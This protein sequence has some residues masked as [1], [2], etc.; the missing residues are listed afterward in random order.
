MPG[1]TANIE[2]KVVA[3]AILSQLW[4]VSVPEVSIRGGYIYNNTF[5]LDFD[6]NRVDVV[7]KR[8]NNLFHVHMG[9]GSADLYMNEISSNGR[10]WPK[11]KGRSLVHIN[12][13]T[14]E[15]DVKLTT[16]TNSEGSVV[17]GVEVKD[18][19]LEMDKD[20]IIV[21]MWGDSHS[22]FAN[23]MK[24]LYKDDMRSAITKAAQ[25]KLDTITNL[26]S[27]DDEPGVTEVSKGV[28]FDWRLF[29]APTIVNN[30]L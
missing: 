6:S 17:L 9:S 30:H 2:L 7:K 1:I 16:K 10:S 20:D 24:I 14:F 12:K 21:T 26:F 15:A 22:D 13:V 25:D 4:N 29:E 5:S 23:V 8:E 28:G 11:Y 19:E 27:V 18:M 3:E